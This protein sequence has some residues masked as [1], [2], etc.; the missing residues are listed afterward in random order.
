MTKQFY[1]PV[2]PWSSSGSWHHFLTLILILTD[3]LCTLVPPSSQ[4]LLTCHFMKPY[5]SMTQGL[6]MCWAIFISVI[7]LR[8]SERPYTSSWQFHLCG[9]THAM[10]G[11]YKYS[12]RNHHD[13]WNF[14]QNGSG[15]GMW[16]GL[17]I[18]KLQRVTLG[19]LQALEMGINSPLLSKCSL[20]IG[21]TPIFP[22]V[23]E[24]HGE[25]IEK[26]FS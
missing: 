10:I 15:H 19:T 9:H 2:S 22:S 3:R 5:P 26:I 8:K 14:L 20:V 13:N 4:L 12:T 6:L 1:F 7:S 23:Y 17:I 24:S 16:S 21:K 25:K 11:V 18:V